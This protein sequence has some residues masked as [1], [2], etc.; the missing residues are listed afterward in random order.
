LTGN[1]PLASW[2]G[3]IPLSNGRYFSFV[4]DF[5]FSESKRCKITIPNPTAR[6]IKR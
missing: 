6:A 3:T 4:E 5:G 1:L 2:N